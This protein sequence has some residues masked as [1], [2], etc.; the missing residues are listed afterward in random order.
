MTFL[1]PLYLI[2]VLAGAIPLLIHLFHRRRIKVVEF[3]SLEFLKKIEGRKTRWFRVREVLLLVL[4]SVALLL[5]A[6]AISR[7]VL[8]SSVFGSLSTHARSSSVFVVD[9]SFSMGARASQASSFEQAKTRAID[10][11]RLLDKGDEVFLVFASDLSKTFFEGPVHDRALVR[12]AVLNAALTSR[13]TDYRPA[14]E[15]ASAVMEDSRNLNKEIYLFTDMQ[16]LGFESFSRG[17]LSGGGG[18]RLYVFDA[19]PAGQVENVA[20]EDLALSDPLLFEG[21]KL[22]LAATLRNHGQRQ[23]TVS[24]RSSLDGREMGVKEVALPP[25]ATRSVEVAFS[26]EGEGLHHMAVDIGE[27]GLSA[28]NARYLSFSVP[29]RAR[30]ALVADD[31]DTRSY[32]SIALSP[33]EGLSLFSPRVFASG[34]FPSIPLKDYQVLALLDVS[35]LSSAD[36]L[37]IVNFVQSGGGLFVALGHSVDADFYNS[38]L[39]PK[40]GRI[41]LTEQRPPKREAEFFLRISSGDYGHPVLSQFK[42]KDKGDLS[43]ARIYDRVGIETSSR[44]VMRLSDTRPLLVETELGEGKVMVSSV[45]MDGSLSDLPLRAVYVPLVHRI[46]RY[47][48]IG[49]E[50]PHSLSVG[51]RLSLSTNGLGQVVCTPPGGKAILLEPRIRA[52]RAYAEY[53]ETEVPGIY[54]MSMADTVLAYFSVNPSVRESDLA[55]ATE[56]ETRVHL[57]ELRPRFLKSSES[58]DKEIFSVRLGVELTN[59]FIFSVLFLLALEMFIAGRWRGIRSPEI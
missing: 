4:R 39:L 36:V 1:N 50:V 14:L 2:G 32:L 12:R 3:S 19:S 55:K 40:L 38:I 35:S 46:F 5:L 43:I 25:G 52:G 51:D 20:I 59:P 6:L 30:V 28:D 41:R 29:G 47:L 56:E 44:I 45:P 57:A 34:E 10:I 48:S 37:K 58:P 17:A 31:P 16:R 53:D 49:E 11:L 42:D 22:S 33:E 8:R 23:S 15:M 24:L 21:S 27:D 13:P 54:T 7:P 9:N 18:K 26:V